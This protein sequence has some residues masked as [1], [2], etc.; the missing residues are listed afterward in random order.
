LLILKGAELPGSV[1][2]VVGN[3][4]EGGGKKSEGTVFRLDY[5]RAPV[6]CECRSIIELVVAV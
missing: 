1:A 3:A 6:G 5:V 4:L 2:E